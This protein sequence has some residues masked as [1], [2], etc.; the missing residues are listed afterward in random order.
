MPTQTISPFDSSLIF[1]TDVGSLRLAIII[2]R[3][4]NGTRRLGESEQKEPCSN[5]DSWEGSALTARPELHT[6]GSVVCSKVF[7]DY[8]NVRRPPPSLNSWL[9]LTTDVGWIR[10]SSG[11][12]RLRA[13]M[14]PEARRNG[15]GEG[16]THSRSPTAGARAAT[17]REAQGASVVHGLSRCMGT[18]TLI[19]SSLIF[20]TD[21]VAIIHC[22]PPRLRMSSQY[23]QH[24][25][26]LT[27]T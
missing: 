2:V 25:W 8:P 14:Q 13:S 10:T 21:V 17:S 22:V 3:T 20:N 6:W 23:M 9:I 7:A 15:E 27:A 26:R 19:N 16:S 5:G 18:I 24:T 4:S 1:A 12:R 11:A